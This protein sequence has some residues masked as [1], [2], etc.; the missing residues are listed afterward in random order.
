MIPI[1]ESHLSKHLGGS[2]YTIE[3]VIDDEMR[4]SLDNLSRTCSKEVHVAKLSIKGNEVY[5]VIINGEK[6]PLKTIFGN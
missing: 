2:V 1:E 3:Q 5:T 4:T 6:N